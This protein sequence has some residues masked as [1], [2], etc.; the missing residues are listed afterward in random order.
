MVVKMHDSSGTIELCK[1]I[2]IK[3]LTLVYAYLHAY[4][5][6]KIKFK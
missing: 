2:S 5:T 6:N 4:K 1:I 3:R